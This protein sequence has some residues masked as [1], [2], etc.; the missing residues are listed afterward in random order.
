DT[1]MKRTYQPSTTRR[2]R[3]HGFLVRMK[4]RGGRAVLNARR[5]KGRKR[6]AAHRLLKTDEFSSVF[7]FGKRFRGEVWTLLLIDK[8]R[9][10]KV[11]SDENQSQLVSFEPTSRLGVVVGKRHL[12]RAVDRN[13]AKRVARTWFRTRRLQLPLGDY[14]LRLDRPIR[15]TSARQFKQV[16]WKD[17]QCLEMQLRRFYRLDPT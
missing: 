8:R 1:N 16:C 13:C 3:T 11:S 6:V 10:Q 15:S 9:L 14:I 17:F 7:S 12:K 5:A 2:K 4:T